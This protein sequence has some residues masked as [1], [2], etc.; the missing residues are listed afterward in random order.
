MAGHQQIGVDSAL[1][2]ADDEVRLD[3]R[4]LEVRLG[5]TGPDVVSDVSFTVQAGQVLGL[6]GESGSGKTTV[7]LAL[8]GHARRGLSISSG[9]VRVDGVDLLR[10]P[11]ARLRAVRGARVAY[12]P[13]DPSAALNPALRVGTQLREAIRVHPGAVED[14][15]GRIRE[16]LQEARLDASSDLLRRYPHQLSGGQQQRVGLAMAFACRPSLIVLDEPTTG[17]DV[18]TQRHVLDTIRSLC[19][20]YGV[21]AVYVSHDLAVVSGLVSDVAVMYSGRIIEVGATARVFGDPLHPYTRGLLSAVPSPVQATTLTGIEGQP[22]RPGRRPV[23]CSFAPRCGFAISECR[24]RPPEPVLIDARAVRCLR[25]AQVRESSTG[26][27]AAL[28]GTAA[29]VGEVPVL[30]VREVS[31]GYGRRPVLTGIDLDVPAESCVAVVGE[32]GSGKTTLAR[33]IVGLHRHWTGDISFEGASLAA[34][35]RDRPRQV[36]RRVQYVFQNPY[37]SLNPRKTVGQIV[38]QPLEQYLRLGH[39]ER[40]QRA[41]RALADVSLGADFLSRYPDQLSGGERQRVAIAR[42]L[43]VEPDLLICDEVTSALDVSVQAVIVELLRG[44]Q[45]RRRI[46]LIFITH[47]LALVR[48]IAQSVVVLRDGA[49]VES[50]PVGQVLDRPAD[51]YTARLMQDVPKLTGAGTPGPSAQDAAAS[52]PAAP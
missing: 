41:A 4:G 51:P 20:A 23:G 22:P 37:T 15:D 52:E 7:V 38:A 13:Q 12:V 21:A 8:L 47:N 1:R 30:T 11:A 26:T 48:S 29:D 16:V 45:T 24:S 14:P 28:G 9:E 18:S 33:C 35:A 36:L 10:L 34:S 25:V 43:V 2:P 3:V 31:A 17:L 42:A 32:S 49:V 5:R 6:V 46:A 19:R 27:A 40:S 50:G 39:R 44:L